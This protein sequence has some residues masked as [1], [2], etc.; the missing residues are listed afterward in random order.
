MGMIY[1]NLHIK[2]EIYSWILNSRLRIFELIRRIYPRLI[3][4]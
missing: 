2:I 4:V 1:L 3:L